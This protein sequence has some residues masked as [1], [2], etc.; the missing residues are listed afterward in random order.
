MLNFTLF[1]KWKGMLCGD[2]GIRGRPGG[3]F[4]GKFKPIRG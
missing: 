4:A 2:V 3:V 1:K